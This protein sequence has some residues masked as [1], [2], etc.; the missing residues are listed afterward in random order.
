MNIMTKPAVTII[1]SPRERFSCTREALQSIYQY[2]TAPFNLIYVD[3]GSPSDIKYYLQAQSKEHGFRLIRTDHYL[4]PNCARNLGL[5]EVETDYVIFI[6]NDVI[7][8]AGWLE[9]LIECA[10]ETGASVVG[11]L[12][13]QDRPI[14]EKVH[15]AG[16]ES[17]VAVKTENGIESRHI[18]EEIYSQGRKVTAMRDQLKRQKTGLAEFHCLLAHMSVFDQ[19]GLLDEA[20]LNTKEHVDFCML[21]EQAGGS[22][23]FEPES[24]VTYIH[25]LPQNL[26]DLSYFMLRWSNQWELSSLHRLRDKWK[27]TEDDYFKGRYRNLGWRR[28]MSIIQPVSRKLTFGRG[29]KRLD[30]LL[31]SAD[32]ILNRYL[33]DRYARRIAQRT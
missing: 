18:F 24:L 13:C 23:Y 8:S 20:L 27:L 6:D 12:I 14:H 7:V 25:G 17:G 29:S 5:K 16:G 21:V 11:P 9:P 32:K 26:S 2:T 3:G 22:V 33:T 19:I 28:K 10:E 4:S 31:F 15:C 1:V 30:K